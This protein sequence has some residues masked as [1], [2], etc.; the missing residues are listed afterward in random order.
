M[1]PHGRAPRRFA[2]ARAGLR[3]PPVPRAVP[4]ARDWIEGGAADDTEAA[5]TPQVGRA[6]GRIR[7]LHDR[8][9]DTLNRRPSRED[10]RGRRVRPASRRR[11]AGRNAPAR[12]HRAH[13]RRDPAHAGGSAR[14]DLRH[15]Q[16]EP[17]EGPR[18][19]PPARLRLRGP[20]ARPL[21]RQRLL[22]ARER[23]R[24]VPP[25]PRAHPHA[26]GAQDARAPL[27]P[28]REAARARARD[29]PD[30]LRQVDDP[31]RADRPHQPHARRA[32][33]HDRG[34]DRVP[35]LAPQVH[36]QPARDRHRRDVVRRRPP[37]GAAPGPRRDP[38]RRDAR[39]RDDLDSAD[40][41]RDGSPRLRHAAHPERAA[42]DRPR[43]RRVPLGAAGPDPRAARL[44]AGGDRHPEPRPDRRRPR[45]RR[46]A[47][48]PPARRRRAEPDP[49]GQG[50]AG[51]L[52]HAD[53]HAPRHADHGAGARRS[54]A[55]PGRSASSPP[56]R[57]PAGP[58]SSSPCSSAAACRP[59]S[60][61]PSSGNLKTMAGAA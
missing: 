46:R 53:Q 33:P 24:C 15:P 49:A 59:S 57:G 19:R 48:D 47:G 14:P 54:G 50:R 17:A 58:I 5:S 25:H 39:P 56:S 2:S 52:G 21:P 6:A 61:S 3:S 35:A 13:P 55:A 4:R 27:R 38:R 11:L 42:D 9:Q 29:R 26:R 31:R 7:L 41:R 12:P 32:H 10:G 40:R 45:P 51:L 23:R 28:V 20:R 60:S 43:H 8:H 44:D 36:R 37:R 30:R 18:S 16:H 1:R 22:P 34:P